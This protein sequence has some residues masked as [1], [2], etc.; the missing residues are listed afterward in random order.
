MKKIMLHILRDITLGCSCGQIYVLI[1]L[2]W[3]GYSHLSMFILAAICGVFFIDH[4]NNYLSFD[5]N[6]LLQVGISTILCTFAEGMTGLYVNIYKGWNVWDYSNLPFTF[7]WGQCNLLFVVAWALIIGLFG[8][9]YC[10]IYNYLV[11]RIEPIPYYHIGKHYW[12]FAFLFKVREK[13]FKKD[14]H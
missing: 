4:I 6:Y 1:E 11:C 13:L 9:F 2:L 3:R 14:K 5:L 7:F 12:D 8:I 10:D